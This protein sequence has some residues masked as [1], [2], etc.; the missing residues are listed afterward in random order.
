MVSNVLLLVMNAG[1]LVAQMPKKIKTMKIFFMTS[2]YVKNY[3]SFV[4]VDP[5]CIIP[6]ACSKS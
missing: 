5:K 2:D 3:L 4:S 6:W 1:V